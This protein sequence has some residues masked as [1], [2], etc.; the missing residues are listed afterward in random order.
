MAAVTFGNFVLSL[1][2]S[3]DQDRQR[4]RDWSAVCLSRFGLSFYLGNRLALE[5]S[6]MEFPCGSG[7]FWKFCTIGGI[8]TPLAILSPRDWSGNCLD[9]F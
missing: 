4:Q 2:R 1:L 3:P 6:S 7:D 5:I 8:G 9:A